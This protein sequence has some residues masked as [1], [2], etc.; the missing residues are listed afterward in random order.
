MIGSGHCTQRLL[1]TLKT[2]GSQRSRAIWSLL[3]SETSAGRRANRHLRWGLPDLAWNRISCQKTQTRCRGYQMPSSCW[4][5]I[6]QPTLPPSRPSRTLDSI[7]GASIGLVDVS[8][9]RCGFR[10][11]NCMSTWRLAWQLWPRD[12]LKMVEVLRDQ[13]TG[14]LVE[15]GDVE[16]LAGAIVCLMNE[17]A[18]IETEGRRLSAIATATLLRGLRRPSRSDLLADPERDFKLT[19]QLLAGRIE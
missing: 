4:W 6:A 7:F 18:R 13:E 15:L 10:A 2:Q 3:V 5:E 8:S 14:V 12:L 1:A 9:M 11:C 19:S 17:P 16:T